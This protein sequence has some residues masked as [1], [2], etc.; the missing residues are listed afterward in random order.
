MMRLSKYAKIGWCVVLCWGISQ[1]ALGQ[2]ELPRP[3]YIAVERSFWGMKY[4]YERQTIE[5]PLALQIPL[6]QLQ[7]PEVSSRFLKFKSQ[8]KAM[9]WVNIASAGV[10]LYT[11]FNRDK[12]SN[13]FYWTSLGSALVI[14]T[15]LNFRSTVHLS[16][17]IARY[18]QLQLQQS[19]I[20]LSINQTSDQTPVIGL[21]WKQ[22]F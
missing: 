9:Q 1:A 10:S 15:Y 8:R 22:T 5:N 13:N 18:N 3:K 2:T 6:L 7:D 14:T 12:V 19:R 21:G 20:G 17:S 4:I 16:K 11:I